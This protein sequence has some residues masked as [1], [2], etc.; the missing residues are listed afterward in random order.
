MQVRRVAAGEV[1]AAQVV[2][3]HIVE[4]GIDVVAQLVVALRV[5][6]MAYAALHIVEVDIAPCDGYAV[7]GDDACETL[8][9][10]APRLGQTQG[11][12]YVALGVEAFRYAEIGCGKTPI[13]MWRVLPPKH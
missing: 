4:V 9:L 13:Y 12:V 1:H 10:I 7:H 3:V 2:H 6:Q 8:V 5:H 11:D